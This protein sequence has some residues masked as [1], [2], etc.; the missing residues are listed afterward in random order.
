MPKKSSSTRRA[1]G[2]RMPKSTLAK[3]KRA[4]GKQ[5]VNKA[6][7]NMDTHFLRCKTNAVIRPVPGTISTDN[8]ISVFF[9]LFTTGSQPSFDVR[10]NTDFIVNTKL[11]DRFRINRMTV[12]FTPKANV[13]DMYYAQA[14]TALA[15]TG[16]NTIHTAIDRDGSVPVST[17]A[18]RKYSSYK[19]FSLLK[20]FSRSYSVRWPRGVWLDCDE[21]LSS[22]TQ[23][24]RT[25][26]CSGGI[27]IYAENVLEDILEALNE[28]WANCE[29][30]YDLVFE[31]KTYRSTTVD[32][33]GNVI[34]SA[35][36]DKE[37]ANPAGC[38]T[39]V[40]EGV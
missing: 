24:T 34:L 8:Y 2:R 10:K 25:I 14:D 7:K 36:T 17:D 12:K 30:T 21:F 28:P 38:V 3:A 4:L 29:I 27:S 22:D 1:G 23:I 32:A 9:P 11:Y 35:Y 19:Q 5:M 31:G 15:L 20:P 18:F 13:L 39:V 16:T 37:V 6:K 40:S 26:G 33:S